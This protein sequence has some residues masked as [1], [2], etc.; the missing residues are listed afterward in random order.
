MHARPRQTGQ[1]RQG[2]PRLPLWLRG[3]E[4]QVSG[5][6][7][8]V[9]LVRGRCGAARASLLSPLGSQVR[10]SGG[11]AGWDGGA[12]TWGG[13]SLGPTAGPV[14]P[15]TG[16]GSPS[17]GRKGHMDGG[18]PLGGRT[19][20]VVSAGLGRTRGGR[21]GR[22]MVGV[23]GT[24]GTVL[25]TVVSEALPSGA[26]RGQGTGWQAAARASLG[27]APTPSSTR[28]GGGRALH[29]ERLCVGNALFPVCRRG[30]SRG[31]ALA[32]PQG[33]RPCRASVCRSWQV[34]P[35]RLDL[36]NAHQWWREKGA[37]PLCAPALRAGG[38][39]ARRRL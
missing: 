28:G 15:E 9:G 24:L 21:C 23:T 18:V 35:S 1:G 34:M 26:P 4:S 20:H 32:Q 11:R 7:A 39:G 27:G 14:G 8:P 25:A 31:A 6:T 30:R 36:R 13:I 10:P 33:C 29:L 37:R 19:W 12:W 16:R 22:V 17:A 3:G 5:R 2:S 38:F